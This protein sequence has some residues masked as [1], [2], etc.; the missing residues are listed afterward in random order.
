MTRVNGAHRTWL[1]VGRAGFLS[2]PVLVAF[3]AWTTAWTVYIDV[4]TAQQ[5]LLPWLAAA[6]VASVP[7]VVMLVALAALVRRRWTDGPGPWRAV[8][9]YAVAGALR[10]LLMWTTAN[11]LDLP[12]ELG[13]PTRVG[14]SAV[15]TLVVMGGAS[16]V[17]ARLD[18][19]NQIMRDLARRHQELATLQSTLDERINQTRR[20][21]VEQVEQELGPTLVRLRADL[22][23][24]ALSTDAGVGV[25]IDRFRAAVADVVRPLSRTLAEPL[26]QPLVADSPHRPADAPRLRER[27]PMAEVIAP[28]MSTGIVVALLSLS[29][30]A[31]SPTDNRSTATPIRAVVFAAI[32][33]CGLMVL[34]WGARRMRWMLTLPAL[35]SAL[36][37]T[38]ILMGV[39]VGLA[40]RTTTSGLTEQ[41]LTY[42]AIGASIGMLVPL[43][44]SCALALQK[45]AHV[46]ELRSAKTVEEL[47][48]L[49][50]V[51]RRE[52]WR[53]RRRLAVIVHGPVQSALVAAA[54]TMSRPGFSADQARGLAANLDQAMAHIDRASG[55]QPPF[56]ATARDLVTLWIDSA[57]IDVAVTP[58]ATTLMDRD[59]SLNLAVS[60]VVR[61]GVSNAIRHGAAD[62][63][64]VAVEVTSDGLMDVVIDDDGDG[65]AASAHPGLGSA[66][67]DELA[68]EWGLARA[69]TATRL[70]VILGVQETAAAGN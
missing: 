17:A 69:G 45:I 9:I 15:S 12:T 8:T 21:L 40:A 36:T 55:P 63:I 53:E 3:V 54:V 48:V 2:T 20:D 13:L 61:E 24:L 37:A 6:V 62:T 26:D 25:A 19:H 10:G 35:L 68:L 4:V 1:D 50:A 30:V 59:E 29:A 70:R 18:T 51:L 27:I 60:E 23:R 46:A 28:S 39:V 49:T 66:M 52:L 41:G 11:A 14:N 34:R 38:F 56:A 16:V 67:L 32:L 43:T 65:P 22:D 42:P 57:R 5:P 58:E 44:V 33:W 7:I 64:V 47:E 31:F